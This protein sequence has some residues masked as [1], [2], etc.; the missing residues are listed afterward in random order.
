MSWKATSSEPRKTKVK[1]DAP[2]LPAKG[3]IV[4]NL[5]QV[6]KA[7]QWVEAKK[8]CEHAQ[9]AITVDW[10]DADNRGYMGGGDKLRK[11]GEILQVCVEP[12]C[13]VHPKSYEKAKRQGD[14]HR[15]PAEEKAAEEKRKA[16]AIEESKL[17]MAVASKALDTITAI[18]ADVLRWMAIERNTSSYGENRKIAEALM[19]GFRKTLQAAKV[20]SAEFAKALA[21]VSLDHLA[22]NGWQE[23][24]ANRNTFLASIKRLGCSYIDPWKKP[25]KPATKKAQAKKAAKKTASKPVKKSAAKPI[26]GKLSPEVK[27]RILDAQKKRWAEQGVH[28]PATKRRVTLTDDAPDGVGDV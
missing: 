13:K 4:I 24:E 27:K 2:G 16:A 23:P 17:R 14:A 10:S 26:K 18:P 6:F 3:S 28:V 5:A 21:V 22:A 1:S 15:D 11:P 7:G 20:D 25:A 19:P 9:A 12:K 8:K